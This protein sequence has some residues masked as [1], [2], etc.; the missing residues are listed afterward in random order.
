[1]W[2]AWGWGGIRALDQAGLA[3]CSHQ[4]KRRWRYST[5]KVSRIA[6]IRLMGSE[7]SGRAWSNGTWP[8][9]EQDLQDAR[10][11][12]LSWQ[13]FVDRLRTEVGRVLLAITGQMALRSPALEPR[14]GKA[15]AGHEGAGAVLA[16]PCGQ[17][18]LRRT[19]MKARRATRFAPCVRCA[20]TSAPSQLTKRVGTRA[21]F[22]PT[23]LRQAL[24]T[25]RTLQPSLGFA[26]PGVPLLSHLVAEAL[27]GE[28]L[29]G[30]SR[31]A[32]ERLRFGDG[33][34]PA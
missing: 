2:R 24:L 34:R 3:C 13:P 19:G 7:L 28:A 20:Q 11:R 18:A 12:V 29:W 26:A 10:S 25:A 1:M 14:G 23:R 27:Q 16:L 15:E 6:P 32:A 17:G 5:H 4:L 22:N 33:H 8:P 31:W 30:P 9:M 21:A